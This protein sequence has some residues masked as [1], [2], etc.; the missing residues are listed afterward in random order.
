MVVVVV[1]GWNAPFLKIPFTKL[2]QAYLQFRLRKA[3]ECT[4]LIVKGIHVA[5]VFPSQSVAESFIVEAVNIGAVC[6][7]DWSGDIA[8]KHTLNVG[9]C[10]VVDPS[11]LKE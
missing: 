4:D 3:K 7:L 5:L 11:F 1:Q 8:S 2:L 6:K 10:S 9:K